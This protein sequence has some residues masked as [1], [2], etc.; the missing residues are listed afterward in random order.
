MDTTARIAEIF[1]L[2]IPRRSPVIIPSTDRNDLAR[3]FCALGYQVG[4]EIGTAAGR[5]AEVLTRHNPSVKLFCVDPYITYNGYRDYVDTAFL[6]SLA[7]EAKQRL[8]GR[9]VQF[10]YDYSV[11]ASESFPD[12]SLD[13]VYIDANH[14]WPYVTQ[15]IY[16]WSKK[17]RPGG[18]VAGHDWYMSGVKNSKCNVQGAVIGY[19]H[20][21]K[22]HPYFILGRDKKLPDEVRENCRSWFWVQA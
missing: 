12:G 1:G 7:Q 20:A 17:V 16:Y 19:A 18:I 11:K 14:E 8:T 22:V 9:N 4:A 10:V 2:T 3:L 5:Y 13:F 21:F 15:D 6:S